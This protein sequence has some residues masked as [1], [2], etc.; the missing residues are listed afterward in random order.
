MGWSP[1]RALNSRTR[2]TTHSLS[3][4]G[5]TKEREGKREG[6]SKLLMDDAFTLKSN[7]SQG[8]PPSLSVSF[9]CL[10]V[11]FFHSFV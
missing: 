7:Q 9:V 3:K 6:G 2:F 11:S 5:R 1:S 10:L 8:L 4:R